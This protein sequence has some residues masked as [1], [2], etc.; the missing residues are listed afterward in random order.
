MGNINDVKRGRSLNSKITNND[1]IVWIER[2]LRKYPNEAINIKKLSE[3][4]SIPRHYWYGRKII[5]NKIVEVNNIKYEE[6][7]IKVD[8]NKNK[9]LLELPD[10]DSLVENNYRSK[11]KLKEVISRYFDTMQ[12]FY[13]SACEKFEL[14]KELKKAFKQIEHFEY[15]IK[16]IRL[17]CEKYK[18]IA[19]NYEQ[20]L[21]TFVIRSSE[22]S[23]RKENNI[24]ENIIKLDAS[25]REKLTTNYDELEKLLDGI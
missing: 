25:K 24:K 7:D 6:Y 14:E 11:A 9:H 19:D 13:M 15:E 16:K 3:F 2:Y 22:E 5:H 1:M 12:E 4:S 21:R 23:F 18:K 10:I 8:S 20:Q 17:E